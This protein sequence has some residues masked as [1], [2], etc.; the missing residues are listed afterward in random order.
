MLSPRMHARTLLLPVTLVT[1]T[2]LVQWRLIEVFGAGTTYLI[3]AWPVIISALL[4]GFWGG[5]LANALSLAVAFV[6]PL[7]SAWRGDEPAVMPLRLLLMATV[8][9]MISVIIA[10][11]QSK[12]HELRR[13]TA[14]LEQITD[15]MPVY[16]VRCAADNTFLFVN[17]SY[18][19]RFGLAAA[20]VIGRKIPDVLGAAAY[21][22]LQPYI[23]RVLKGEHV[24]FETGLN[25][26]GIGCR[27]MNCE[28]VP[29]RAADGSV[30]SFVGVIVDVTEQRR[31]AAAAEAD[32]DRAQLAADAAELGTWEWRPDTGA[33]ACSPR[34]RELF[35]LAPNAA[36]TADLFMAT[37]HPADRDR[38]KAVSARITEGA[39][40]G[41][42]RMS[43]YRIVRVS[44]GQERWV[45]ATGRVDAR[46]GG[47]V[48]AIGTVQDVTEQYEARAA[49]EQA[50]SREHSARMQAEEAGRLK[51]EFLATLSH[52]LRTPLN[53]I[54]G[55]TRMLRAGTL[56]R[57]RSELALEIVER[58]ARLQRQLVDDI[59]DVSRIITG[60]LRLNP[61]ILDPV[62]V[63][64]LALDSIRP[65]ADAKRLVL[66]L[67]VRD[68]GIR[69][70]ADPDR[71]Q[72]IIWNILTNAVK[73]TPAG[74]RILIDI[75]KDAGGYAVVTITDTGIGITSDFLPH[76][77]ERFRQGQN[78]SSDH[79]GLGL[80]LAI[81]RHLTEL[82]GGTIA[83]HSDGAGRGSTFTL[84][85]P[86][87]AHDAPGT[88]TAHGLSALSEASPDR[89]PRL[90]GLRV[91][92]VDDDRDSVVLLE[93]TLGACGATVRSALTAIE[94]LRELEREVPDVIL[95]DIALP[96]MDGHEFMRTVRDRTSVN[97]GLVPAI[98]LTAY[99]RDE[100]RQ[101]A[102]AAGYQVHLTKPCDPKALTRAIAGV[103]GAQMS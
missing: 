69:V 57:E 86:L 75:A 21:R 33:V 34:V 19:H 25:Y 64:E 9:V 50:L 82:Q 2:A 92:L 83:A 66:A 71:L 17:H 47:P 65:G 43:E 60:K 74:G 16:V 77:F 7:T 22:T 30:R 10:R 46:E 24:S 59:L 37:V 97:G 12:E 68:D 15:T 1:L 63:V 6:M 26:A 70:L 52:E 79:G 80:G 73:F 61:T 55:Y 32:R 35:G 95:S 38:V 8:G 101:A 100:D 54:L 14:E 4:A 48:R 85:F 18:A 56:P 96:G 72:Q 28:Y 62:E 39:E 11:L 45:R 23:D 93:Q 36:M 40:L 88:W 102:L 78:G 44:D 31:M 42:L 53:A 87:R 41:P 20:E 67:I 76:V 99:G 90:D 3:F 84:R 13:R 49:L 94:G 27:T 5:I 98:A 89:G 51:D 29:E 58:N 103:T 91:L 81:V